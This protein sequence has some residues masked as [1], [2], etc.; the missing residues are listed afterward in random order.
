MY[1]SSKYAYLTPTYYSCKLL[2]PPLLQLHTNLYHFSTATLNY[3]TSCSLDSPLATRQRNRQSKSTCRTIKVGFLLNHITG[4]ANQFLPEFNN[5][6]AKLVSGWMNGRLLIC[7]CYCWRRGGG[8]AA[9]CVSTVYSAA[10][11]PRT[12]WMND[13]RSQKHLLLLPASLL[14]PSRTPKQ[15]CTVKHLLLP[16]I[17]RMRKDRKVGS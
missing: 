9:S 3:K 12:G 16:I 14:W 2:R 15:N 4:I 5:N 10:S 1:G 13:G 8:D 17:I 7:C 11:L 6:V